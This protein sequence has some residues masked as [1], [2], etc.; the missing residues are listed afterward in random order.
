MKW[1]RPNRLTSAQ[2]KYKDGGSPVTEADFAVDAFLKDALLKLL[3][4]AGWLSEETAD[5]KDRLDKRLAWIVDP[6]DGTR[7]FTDGDSRWAVSVALVEDGAPI[8]GIVTA[9]ALG[10]TWRAER[11]AGA[12]LNA[13]PLA[14][15]ADATELAGP[16]P[17]IEKMARALD[18]K[19]ASKTPSLAYRFCAVAEGKFWGAVASPNAHDW[20][21]A[22]ADLIL[23]ESGAV[24]SGLDG[25]ALTYNSSGIKHGA[26]F[27][28]PLSRHEA[29]LKAARK[30]N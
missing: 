18:L 5:T 8:L 13:E 12:R 15:A 19:I 2:I 10:V 7:G 23:R 21:I 25:R 22:A 14:P 9:P 26:L 20:D 16:R 24:L 3:P 27:A 6:I 28:A 17:M 29:L 30:G 4:E 1:F 11:G